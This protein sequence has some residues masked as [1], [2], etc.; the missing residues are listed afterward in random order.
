MASETLQRGDK[1]CLTRDEFYAMWTM[2]ATRAAINKKTKQQVLYQAG[3]KELQTTAF[4]AH[5][6]CYL[7]CAVIY[8]KRYMMMKL[9][10]GF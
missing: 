5:D 10:H 2:G 7:T 9:R 1:I 8:P 4:A 3:L 6:S